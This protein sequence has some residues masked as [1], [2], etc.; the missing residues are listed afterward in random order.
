MGFLKYLSS[1]P[2][3]LLLCVLSG[4][5]IGWVFPSI[6]TKTLFLGQIYLNLINM[7]A[8]PLL[9]VAT[10]F[11]LRQTLLLP[12]PGKRAVMIVSLAVGLVFLCAVLGTFLSALAGLGQNVSANDRSHLGM[13]VQSGS[14]NAANNE[15]SLYNSHESRPV[16][17]EGFLSR[18]IPANFFAALSQGQV[19]AVLGGALFFGLAFS[20]LPKSK[21]NILMGMFEAI[22]RTFELLILKINLFIPLLAFGMAAFFTA[23]T[24]TQTLHAMGSF[25]SSFFL[26]ALVCSVGATVFVWRNSGLSASVVLSALKTPALISLTSSSTTASIPDTIL[27]MSSKLGFSRGIVELLVPTSSVFMRSGAALYFS[28]LTIFVANIYGV[29]I[30]GEK[31]LLICFGSTLAALAS[32]G[33]NSLAVVGF[34]SIV[35]SMLN[36]PIEAAL[37]LFI[38]I[39]LICEGP[40]NLVTLL[41][42]CVLIVLVSKGL[43]SERVETV[44]EID[45][46]NT[47]KINFIF[48][49]T[50]AIIILI[51]TFLMSIL[52][53]FIGI[54]VGM[55]GTSI[56][57]S[58]SKHFESNTGIRK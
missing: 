26:L 5:V 12:V 6:G 54:G 43:P 41:L 48:S 57:P 11:G 40:R 21:S 34:S 8:L 23:N 42:V 18:I 7:A 52:I 39:D 36:L 9:V 37:A 31:L 19:L 2:L 51:L 28:I 25:I 1:S 32:A 13:L 14:G 22:Y 10:F 47:E 38:A 35:L 30:D 55:K 45:K 17:S 24:D 33:N 58:S 50:D 20:G 16:K 4:G 3:G 53:V 49:K 44:T 56:S 29:S 15:L 27:T 46:L